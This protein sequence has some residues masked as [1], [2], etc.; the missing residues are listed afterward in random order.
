MQNYFNMKILSIPENVAFARSTVGA[1]CAGAD[2]SVEELN[3]VRTAVSEAV[4]NCIV[5][6]YEGRKTE[7]IEITVKLLDEKAVIE[8]SDRGVGIPDI[9]KALEPFFTTKPNEERS[10]MGFTIMQTFTD[11]LKVTSENGETKV[12]LTKTFKN[13]K[14]A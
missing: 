9:P 3:D 13:T 10:G 4:T 7:I 6:G 5:H 1:F 11:D 2:P 12:V 14:N 8:I